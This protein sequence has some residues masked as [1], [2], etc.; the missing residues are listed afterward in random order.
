MPPQL[1]NMSSLLLEDEDQGHGKHGAAT[2]GMQDPWCSLLLL[3]RAMAR[4]SPQVLLC[5]TQVQLCSMPWSSGQQLHPQA[6]L[7]AGS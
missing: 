4:S 2:W 6:F 1:P 3:A 7:R 5:A